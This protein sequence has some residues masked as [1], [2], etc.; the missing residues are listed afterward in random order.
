MGDRRARDELRHAPAASFVFGV[1]ARQQHHV[2][3]RVVIV[4]VQRRNALPMQQLSRRYGVSDLPAAR[5]SRVVLRRARGGLPPEA[6]TGWRTVQHVGRF[7][8]P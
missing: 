7:V 5:S 1:A 8:R 3:R 2:L 4:L 6:A